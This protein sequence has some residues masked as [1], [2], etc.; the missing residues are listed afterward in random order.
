MISSG[1]IKIDI[2]NS[3]R[4]SEENNLLFLGLG[5]HLSVDYKICVHRLIQNFVF[6]AYKICVPHIIS[7]LYEK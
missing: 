1:V 5:Y 3:F 2:I 6:T 4:D 7:E